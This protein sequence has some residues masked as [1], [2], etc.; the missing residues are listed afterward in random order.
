MS[1]VSTSSAR[2]PLEVPSDSSN[3][4][5]TPVGELFPSMKPR[6]TLTFDERHTDTLSSGHEVSGGSSH[7]KSASELFGELSNWTTWPRGNG[8]R[9]SC[10]SIQPSFAPGDCTR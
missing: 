6:C 9:K 5:P 1:T 3:I 4:T 8:P 7:E 10:P 2:P